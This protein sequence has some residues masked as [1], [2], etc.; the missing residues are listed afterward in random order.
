MNPLGC[1]KYKYVYLCVAVSVRGVYEPQYFSPTE[2][3]SDLIEYSVLYGTED[4]ANE[5]K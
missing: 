1:L 5:E 3:A 2:S 4:S